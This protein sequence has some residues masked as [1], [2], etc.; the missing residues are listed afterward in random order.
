MDHNW[1][2]HRNVWAITKVILNFT[3]SLGEK[4]QQ[5]SFRGGYFFEMTSA[6]RSSKHAKCLFMSLIMA[7][8]TT[9][10][11]GNDCRWHSRSRIR[12]KASDSDTVSVCR[13]SV[14]TAKGSSKPDSSS[15]LDHS[16]TSRESM[17]SLARTSF[18]GAL[19]SSS[20]LTIM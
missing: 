20:R 1:C 5:N 6:V 3:G 9:L 15:S 13:L 14:C 18:G 10:Q 11:C 4:I 7:L 16:A 19:T 12:G 17:F 8:V 2:R